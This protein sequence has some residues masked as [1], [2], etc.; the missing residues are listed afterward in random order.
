MRNECAITM[1]IMEMVMLSGISNLNIVDY[2][3]RKVLNGNRGVTSARTGGS[4]LESWQ[5]F[6][7]GGKLN[8]SNTPCTSLLFD[9]VQG[10][11]VFTRKI[12][13]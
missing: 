2:M 7:L 8:E 9:Q 12:G 11:A 5:G 4:R 3:D 6:L 1:E 10:E 13:G